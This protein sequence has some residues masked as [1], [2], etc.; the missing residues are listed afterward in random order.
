MPSI[1]GRDGEGDDGDHFSGRPGGHSGPQRQ[2]PG[3]NEVIA[4]GNTIR[5]PLARPRRFAIRRFEERPGPGS[6]TIAKGLEKKKKKKKPKK[7]NTPRKKKTKKPPKQ[8]KKKKPISKKKK[9][10]KGH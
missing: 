4:A 10:K 2:D 3:I 5:S 8:K 7:K 1:P 6:P 9:K